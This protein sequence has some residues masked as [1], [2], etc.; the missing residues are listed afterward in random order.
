M[1]PDGTPA[2]VI[3]G[4]ERARVGAAVSGEGRGLWVEVDPLDGQDDFSPDL[5]ARATEYRA[6][7][8]RLLELAGAP[9]IL[10]PEP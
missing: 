4:I 6:L 1:H 5:S 2:V 10:T 9:A 8:R 3:R 7:A